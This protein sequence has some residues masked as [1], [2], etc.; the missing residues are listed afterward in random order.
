M[1]CAGWIHIILIN[2]I[3]WNKI[4]IRMTIS[5]YSV[6][7][8]HLLWIKPFWDI[9]SWIRVNE[10]TVHLLWNRR[11]NIP[12]FRIFPKFFSPK[13]ISH[14]KWIKFSEKSNVLAL[15]III[16]KNNNILCSYPQQNHPNHYRIIKSTAIQ[17][18][19]CPFCI[20]SP[21]IAIYIT[22]KKFFA[23]SSFF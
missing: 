13:T 20:F 5:W 21:H 6:S 8:C 2:T 3:H 22:V 1:S 18:I 17:V 19:W 15:F 12:I 16:I 11:M 4:D 9:V 7:E 23:M 14:L 10:H